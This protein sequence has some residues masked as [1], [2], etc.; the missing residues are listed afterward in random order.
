MKSPPGLLISI[1]ICAATLQ[2][3]VDADII[4]PI[5][6]R[7]LQSPQLVTFQ[8]QQFLRAKVPTLALPENAKQWT[9]EADRIR[10]HL[11][12]EVVFHGWPREWVNSP[13]RFEDLGSLP[14]GKGYSLRKLRFV[15]AR[16]NLK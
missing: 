2:A 9:A 1:L 10:R 15:N 14:A 3:Q 7:Q 4:Q 8:L 13:P 11:L 16:V 12:D 5:L 6:T